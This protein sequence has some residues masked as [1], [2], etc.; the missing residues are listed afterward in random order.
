MQLAGM[1]PNFKTF[2]TVLPACA[3]LLDLEHGIEIHEEIIRNGF[4]S[5]ILVESALEE[6][7]CPQNGQL[8]EVQKLFQKMPE[9][10]VVSWNAMISR[11]AQNGHGTEALVFFPQMQQAGM[12]PNSKTF[13]QYSSGMYQFGSSRMGVL[14]ACANMA[15]LEQGM[16]IHEEIIRS[17]FQSDVFMVNALVDVYSKCGS[18]EKARDLFDT[19]HQRDVI[20]WTTM[21]A[22]YAMHGRDEGWQYFECMDRYYHITPA[23]EHYGCMVD[24]LGRAGHS[25]R[26]HK[27]IEL[28]EH[29]AEHLFELD[30]KNAT[31]YMLLSN[32]TLQLVEE[33]QKAQFL[34]HH[35]KTLAIVFGLINTFPGT[36]VL[37]S[38]NL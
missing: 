10:N 6:L 12:K 8:E 27:N 37:F 20:L 26:I 29:V 35:N 5:D 1:K 2:A 38:G 36:T 21:I 31:P 14:P 22:G 34:C 30:L 15:A 17:G 3:N 25:M 9:Q 18:I 33:E 32:I 16:E 19:L 23:M 24:L 13:C 7:I 11:Y 28:G 4:Q